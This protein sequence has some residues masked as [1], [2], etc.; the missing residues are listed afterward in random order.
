M[1]ECVGAAPALIKDGTARCSA[2]GIVLN[3]ERSAGS[4][5]SGVAAV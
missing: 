5:Y 4:T 3:V 1:G 2:A